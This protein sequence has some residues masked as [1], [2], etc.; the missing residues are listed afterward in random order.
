MLFPQGCFSFCIFKIGLRVYILLP[1]VTLF[2]CMASCVCISWGAYLFDVD[3]L[4]RLIFY[5][6]VSFFNRF[7]DGRTS[8]NIVALIWTSVKT[9]N[10][11]LI[12]WTTTVVIIARH[13]IC[14][15]KVLNLQRTLVRKTIGLYDKTGKNSKVYDFTV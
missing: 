10:F 3:S 14:E 4:Y 13:R 6:G 15:N 11:Y 2:F 12:L 1:N 5:I 8:L 9:T 7:Y